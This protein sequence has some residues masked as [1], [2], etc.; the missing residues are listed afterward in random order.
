[1][2]RKG[3][4]NGWKLEVLLRISK[5]EIWQG[6]PSRVQGSVLYVVGNTATYWTTSTNGTMITFFAKRM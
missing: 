3:D 4:G 5:Q 1:M 6:G 2:D